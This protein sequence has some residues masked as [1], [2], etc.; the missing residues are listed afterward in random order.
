M[1]GKEILLDAE[2]DRRSFDY[3]EPETTRITM[4]AHSALLELHARA[5]A[6]HCECLGMNAENVQRAM[7]NQSP[8]YSEDAYLD[9]MKRWGLININAEPII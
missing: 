7:L 1:N 8:A 5:L 6:C 9:S 4:T 2:T 3:C